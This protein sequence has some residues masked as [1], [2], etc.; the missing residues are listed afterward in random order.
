MRRLAGILVLSMMAL[1]AD[2]D[3]R[4]IFERARVLVARNENLAEAIRLYGQ[5][6]TLARTQHALA[7]RAQ[8]E[9]GLL[10]RRLG[11]EAEAERAFRTVLREF[12]DQKTVA[13]LA[14]ARLPAGTLETGI[15]VRQIWT[16]NDADSYGRV[17]PDGRWISFT[18]STG[19]LAVHDIE[20]GENR[21]VTH[22]G[23]SLAE[24]PAGLATWSVFSPDGRRLAYTWYE[25]GS[26]LR[27]IGLDGSGQRTLYR[28]GMGLDV[29]DWSADGNY[30]LAVDHSKRG[31]LVISVA[32][33][34]VRTIPVADRWRDWRALFSQ[35]GKYIAYNVVQP[36]EDPGNDIHIV[37]IATGR[38]VAVVE[39]RANDTLMC[40][41]PDG[42]KLLF[43]SDRSGATGIWSIPIL[44]G[45]AAGAPELLKPDFNGT[46]PIGIT[47]QGSLFYFMDV[48]LRDVF[49]GEIDSTSGK[50]ASPPRAVSQRFVGAKDTPAWSPDGETLIYQAAAGLWLHSMTTGK[51]RSVQPDPPESWTVAQVMRWHP[52]GH[53]VFVKGHVPDGT[54]GL[55][56]VDLQT[57][58]AQMVVPWLI[59][60]PAFSADARTLYHWANHSLVEH[61]VTTGEV[62]PLY[63][64]AELYEIQN[65]N[66]D[67]SPNGKMLAFMLQDVPKGYNSLVVMPVTGG[68][69]RTLLSIRR[70]ERFGPNTLIWT[71]DMQY[72]L[73]SRTL[74]N[75]SMVWRVPL[76]GGPPQETG[77]SMPGLIGWLRLH[78]DGRRVAFL[79]SE[80]HPQI[81]ALENFLA[82][83]GTSRLARR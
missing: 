69:P 45:Q 6:V 11:K 70:P 59:D 83:P 54:Y 46:D 74:N 36:G 16:G 47:R 1:G 52:D 79:N 33:G 66:V 60:R 30:V 3:I 63:T 77:L 55:L 9:Q 56:R 15:S 64:R 32:D 41:S 44:D 17:S 8:Y 22:K 21:P 4:E 75:R 26:E 81:W 10:Y 53:S 27:I 37:S 62:K 25:N 50:V 82:S 39:H 5:V 13:A 19:D 2:P 65:P 28:A 42:S 78:P 7:A 49:V 61:K 35:D 18:Y 68:E 12:P 73:V 80:A 51:E 43:L 23:K 57:G 20:T 58:Q 67:L 38:D 40:W 76:D 71:P 29:D 14:R 31:M 48:G 34:S 72:V 24:S